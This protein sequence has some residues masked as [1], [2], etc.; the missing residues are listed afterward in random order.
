MFY[1]IHQAKLFGK[2][3]LHSKPWNTYLAPTT[4]AK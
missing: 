2:M 1:L 4:V 3:Q